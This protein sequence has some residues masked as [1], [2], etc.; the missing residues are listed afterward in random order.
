MPCARGL[1]LAVKLKGELGAAGGGGFST[2]QAVQMNMQSFDQ[3]ISARLLRSRSTV[4]RHNKCQ[5]GEMRRHPGCFIY[6]NVWWNPRQKISK[7]AVNL[8]FLFQA[9]KPLHAN[10]NLCFSLGRWSQLVGREHVCAA[11]HYDIMGYN[12]S[13]HRFLDGL[14]HCTT[15]IKS[16]K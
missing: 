5:G 7:P 11:G 4:L 6:M 2:E 14:F 8:E 16:L 9:I 12:D 13:Y 1:M 10:K 15:G 3:A